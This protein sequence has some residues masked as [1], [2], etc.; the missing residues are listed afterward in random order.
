[1]GCKD[2]NHKTEHRTPHSPPLRPVGVKW[3]LLPIKG[4]SLVVRKHKSNPVLGRNL[5]LQLFQE[6]PQGSPASR[7]VPAVPTAFCVLASGTHLD[8]GISHI[9]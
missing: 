1:M 9:K 3:W 2:T 6:S 8:Y 5:P 4:G 7:L